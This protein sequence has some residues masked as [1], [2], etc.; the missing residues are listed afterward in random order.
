M[1][2]SNQKKSRVRIITLLATL[3]ACGLPMDGKGKTTDSTEDTPTNSTAS[4][5]TMRNIIAPNYSEAFLQEHLR[6]PDTWYRD[7][8]Y[9]SPAYAQRYTEKQIANIIAKAEKQLGY[10][11]PAEPASGYLA[12]D[13]VG[14]R[15]AMEDIAFERVRALDQLVE[16]ELIEN[17]GRFIPQILNGAWSM[18]ENSF[19][20]ISAHV[21]VQKRKGSLPDINEPIIDL[22]FY[23]WF[24]N[25]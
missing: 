14:D 9:P 16:A 19:W 11:W 1:L 21:Y 6:S 15:N 5:A 24:F 20:G 4:R 17:K 23:N 7:P 13:A 25:L 10:T 18:C 3:A 2:Y 12:F 8:I 22:S